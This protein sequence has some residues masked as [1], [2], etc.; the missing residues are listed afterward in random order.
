MKLEE[1]V[2]RK[3]KKR[4]VDEEKMTNDGRGDG[5]PAEG[6]DEGWTGD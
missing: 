6:E 3:R 4:T 2:K 5:G 1:M